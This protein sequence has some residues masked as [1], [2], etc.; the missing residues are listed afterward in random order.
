M[1]AFR[2]GWSLL[3]DMKMLLSIMEVGETGLSF[4]LAPQKIGK[5]EEDA[6]C[7]D[8]IGGE[9]AVSL[10]DPNGTSVEAE[11]EVTVRRL[12]TEKRSLLG[13]RI[14]ALTKKNQ[15]LRGL[16]KENANLLWER[17]EELITKNQKLRK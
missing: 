2:D 9:D 10:G 11:L 1:S 6:P 3:G 17:I 16:E 15:K 5:K 14:K 4:N 8:L 7:I 13:E 12:D